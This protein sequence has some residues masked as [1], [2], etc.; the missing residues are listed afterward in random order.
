M[1]GG[2]F[3]NR[4]GREGREYIEIERDGV[5]VGEGSILT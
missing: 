3:E 5:H 1:V 2:I 4:V